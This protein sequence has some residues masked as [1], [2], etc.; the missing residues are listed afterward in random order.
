MWRAPARISMN[1]EVRLTAMTSSHCSSF[2]TMNRLS[3]VRPALLTRMSRRP[4]SLAAASSISLATCA[5]LPRSQGT[6]CVREPSSAASFSSLSVCRPEMA[7][8]APCL[9]SARAMP[10]PMPPVTPVTSAVLS[11][12]SN[13]GTSLRERRQRRLDILRR[14]HR[15]CLEARR[16][17]LGEPRQHL[18]RADLV[19]GGDA[20]GGHARHALAPAHG[21]GDLLDEAA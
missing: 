13:M 2:I 16:D 10:P 5:L 18:A 4:P 7:T 14:T 11:L 12:S 9:W 6:M 19:D 17:A 1:V 8:V 21:A 15:G 20:V 3:L